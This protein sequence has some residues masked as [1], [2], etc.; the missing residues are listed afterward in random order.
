[1]THQPISPRFDVQK[2]SQGEKVIVTDERGIALTRLVLL[3]KGSAFTQR[4]RVELGLDGFLPSQVCSL[5][6]Q[7]DR[8]YAS[9][10][11]H[12]NA[13]SKYQFLRG[14]QERQEVLFYALVASHLEEMMPIIYTPTVGEAVANFSQMFQFGR[15]IS[16]ST[17]NIHR[18]QDIVNEFPLNDVRLLVATDSSAILG[19]GDQGYGGLAISIGKLALYTV[20][21]RLSPFHSAPVCLDVGT[22]RKSLTDDPLYVGARH[23]RLRGDEHKAFLDAFVDSVHKRW[24]KAIIQW[25]DLAKDTAFDVLARY[26]DK[27]PSFND[28]IQGTGAVALAGVLRACELKE[29]KLADQRFMIYGAGAG[30]IGVAQAIYDGLIREGLSEEEAR[31]RIFVFDSKG[32]LLDNRKLDAYKLPFAHSL[33]TFEEWEYK[34]DQ[35][36]I[37]D[38]IRQAGI[39]CMLGLS[40]QPG[41]FGQRWVKLVH[42]N[43]HRPIIFGLSNPTSLSEGLPSDFLAWTNGEALVAMGSPFP[44]VIQAGRCFNIGQGNNAFIFPGLGVGAVVAEAKKITDNMVLN[45]AYALAAYTSEVYGKEER[46]FPELNHLRAVC[47]NVAVAVLKAAMNDKVAQINIASDEALEAMV[48]AD[49]WEPNYLPMFESL[50]KAEA[51]FDTVKEEKVVNG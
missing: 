18:A 29:E 26:R 24:P 37:E 48:E 5:K 3:N 49:A 13:I 10:L 6:E 30:G 8:A 41:A 42:E 38:V 21:G 15:G 51:F 27:V 45:A 2:T 7:I 47:K 17:A 40:G 20:G 11:K 14:V 12:P 44:P 4:E 32:L 23:P 46:I 16:L 9:F 28:D 34:G 22:D 1:M 33:E 31:V 35:P 19:I 50:E 43:T 36:S 39:T 25:E